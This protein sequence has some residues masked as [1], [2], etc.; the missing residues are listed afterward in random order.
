MHA[1]TYITFMSTRTRAYTINFIADVIT[2]W[3]ERRRRRKKTN[4]IVIKWKTMEN[5]KVQLKIQFSINRKN[6]FFFTFICVLLRIKRD[7]ERDSCL[8][9]C[10]FSINAHLSAKFSVRFYFFHPRRRSS[11]STSNSTFFR[12][13]CCYCCF[14]YK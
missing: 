13:C 11:F 10:A 12:W 9:W 5:V 6:V 8:L 2:N 7:E 14:C 3:N 1:L 4:S